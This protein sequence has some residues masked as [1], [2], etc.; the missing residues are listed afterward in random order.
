MLGYTTPFHQSYNDRYVRVEHLFSQ[1]DLLNQKKQII[2]KLNP[3]HV[4]EV[5]LLTNQL[6]TILLLEKN[7]WK[8]TEF[9]PSHLPIEHA[10]SRLTAAEKSFVIENMS[11]VTPHV[12]MYFDDLLHASI[13]NN[14]SN[15]YINDLYSQFIHSV[16]AKKTLDTVHD[17][18]D[19]QQLLVSRVQS[20]VTNADALPNSIDALKSSL[21][22]QH[23]LLARLP[24]FAIDKH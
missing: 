10:P 12:G 11:Q 20:V 6:K 19:R 3:Q 22:D 23:A 17:H 16:E 5:S 8:T 21:N 1:H 15:S 4:E 24:P 2:E 14:Q 18:I 13:A 9:H 7:L